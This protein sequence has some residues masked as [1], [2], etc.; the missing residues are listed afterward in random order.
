MSDAADK[1]SERMENWLEGNLAKVNER[2]SLK[3]CGYCFAC[4]ETVLHHRLFCE[5]VECRDDYEARL[6]AQRRNGVTR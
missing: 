6:Q 1:A 3:P 4:G 5:G 2:P